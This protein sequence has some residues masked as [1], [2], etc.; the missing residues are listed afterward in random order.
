MRRAGIRRSSSS[1]NARYTHTGDAGDPVLFRLALRS[2]RPPRSTSSPDSTSSKN[3]NGSSY[4]TT[5]TALTR[6]GIVLIHQQLPIVESVRRGTAWVS[7]PRESIAQLAFAPTSAARSAAPT[8]RS[9]LTGKWEQSCGEN[10][11]IRCDV[12]LEL[13]RVSGLAAG[14]RARQHPATYAEPS[15]STTSPLLAMSS[16]SGQST[17]GTSPTSTFTPYA[18]RERE[19]EREQEGEE[20]EREKGEREDGERAQGAGG[21]SGKKGLTT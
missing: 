7:E 3:V 10:A 21:T 20:R 8:R 14:I 13:E 18:E 15:S 2:R 6:L 12:A 17:I 9:P 11:V 1:R 19:R 4:S 16:T 5:T